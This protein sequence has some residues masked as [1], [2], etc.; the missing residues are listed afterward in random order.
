LRS[1]GDK[2]A[3]QDKRDGVLVMPGEWRKRGVWVRDNH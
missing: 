1:P 2:A 3:F